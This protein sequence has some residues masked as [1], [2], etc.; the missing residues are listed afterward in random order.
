M[1]DLN[2]MGYYH[3]VVMLRI[4]NATKYQEEKFVAWCM[5]K[6]NVIYCSK[7]I[8]HFDFDVSIAIQNLEELH[9]FL[10]EL[11]AE[12]GEIIDSYETLLN[13]KL[14]KLNYILF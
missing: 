13:S 2:K 12:F 7:R 1:L 10:A 14:L 8:G 3:Y 11:K 4:R 6:R 5:I 9:Q